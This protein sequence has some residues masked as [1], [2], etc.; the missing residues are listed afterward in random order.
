MKHFDELGFDTVLNRRG[1]NSYKWDNVEILK[2]NLLPLSVAD[3]DFAAPSEVTQALVNRTE[4]PIYGYEFQPETLKKAIINW[5]HSRHGFEIHKEWLLFKPGV[6]CGVAVSILSLTQKGDGIVIQPPVFPPFFNVVTENERHLLLNPLHYDSESLRYTMDFDSLE[7]LFSE[8]KPRLMV[9]CNPHN[10]IGRVWEKKELQMLGTLCEKH[11]VIVVSDDIH[12]DLIFSGHCYHPLINIS[13]YL[14]NN[15]I[16]MMSPGKSFN[17]P[18]LCFSY[19]VIANNTLKDRLSKKLSAMALNKT[20][21]MS[22]VATQAAYQ[23]GEKWLNSVLGYIWNN[24]VFLKRTLSS[25][26]PWAKTIP[27]EGTFLAWI[28]LR[29]SGLNDNQLSLVIRSK[30]KLILF[31]GHQFGDAGRG[32]MRINLACPRKTLQEAVTRFTTALNEAREDPPPVE[33]MAI[34][35]SSRGCCS[36]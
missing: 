8:Q 2:E 17:I 20:N 24:Y 32:F 26:L 12:A 13:K 21:T 34:P 27:L 11:H 16:Q 9:L 25:E 7:K 36:G 5:Q 28:D 35:V 6:M 15:T 33:I 4:S 14:K 29:A 23:N 30:A 22:T 3:M 1:T 19:A 31:E 18:G 10:P